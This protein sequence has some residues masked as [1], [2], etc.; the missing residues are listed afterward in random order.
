MNIFFLDIDPE[1]CVK[2]YFNKHCIKIILEIAQMLYA[3]HWIAYDTNMEWIQEHQRVLSLDPYRK[4]HV[5][6]PTTKWVRHHEAN[7]RFACKLGL[8]L[9]HEYTLRYGKIHKVQAR[10][11]WLN[12]HIPIRFDVQP[13]Q[14][15]LATCDIPSGCTPVPLA[16]PEKYHSP[17]LL[18]SYRRYYLGDKKHIAQSEKVYD[19][20]CELWGF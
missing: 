12:D 3:A 10:L 15:Y 4:T 14:G 2:Y 11:E 7:Y 5:N 17:S 13:I 19:E 16:M 20:L 8:M 18:A 1:K 6:H 9:C